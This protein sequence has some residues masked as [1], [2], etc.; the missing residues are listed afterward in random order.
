MRCMTV[1]C[2]PRHGYSKMHSKLHAHNAAHNISGSLCSISRGWVSATRDSAL[3]CLGLVSQG[4]LGT[5]VRRREQGRG[6]VHDRGHIR[7]YHETG[8]NI[9]PHQLCSIFVPKVTETSPAQICM[10][11]WTSTT[12]AGWIRNSATVGVLAHRPY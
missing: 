2:A 4:Y 12:I 6:V 5:S 3:Q 7:Y 11:T 8:F 1:L 9:L 10:Y